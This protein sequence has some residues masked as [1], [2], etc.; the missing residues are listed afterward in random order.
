MKKVCVIAMLLLFCLP[1]VYADDKIRIVTTTATLASLTDEIAGD[2]A[3]IHH[4]ASPKRSLHFVAPTPRDVL[5]VKKADVFIHLGLDAEPWRE[6]LLHAAGNVR[7]LGGAAAAIDT[8][9]GVRLL[10]V[11]EAGRLS[12]LEGDIHIFGNPHYWTDPENARVMAE[13]IAEGLS[14]LYPEKRPGFESRLADFKKRLTDAEK[15]WMERMRPYRG[16]KVVTYHNT[17]TY[18]AVRYGLEIVG[19]I[20]PKPGIPPT[21]RHLDA[22]ARLMKKEGVGLIVKDSAYEDRTPNRIAAETGAVVL[23]LAQEVGEA[24]EAKDYVALMNYNVGQFAIS[25]KGGDRD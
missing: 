3:E 13:N 16:S 2:D 17:W 6:P 18:F 9:R 20:E 22:L 5:K 14:L 7:F 23:N 12:R 21:S 24:G 15:E 4:V 8:S 1:S 19:Q 11:P 25:G 10:E